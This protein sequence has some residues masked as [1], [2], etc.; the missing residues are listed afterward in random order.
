MG[1]QRTSDE[2]KE[3]IDAPYTHSIYA[4]REGLTQS[5]HPPK[6]FPLKET[7]SIYLL[8]NCIAFVHDW[9]CLG[10]CSLYFSFTSFEKSWFELFEKEKKER[11]T[12][13]LC[14]E[15]MEFRISLFSAPVSWIVS[16]MLFGRLRLTPDLTK[17]LSVLLTLRLHCVPE[18]LPG[19]SLTL[20]YEVWDLTES[21]VTWLPG[22]R[23]EKEGKNIHFR[24]NAIFQDIHSFK[25]IV[26]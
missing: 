8:W 3:P 26:Y 12:K 19:L 7:Q 11:G 20:R 2:V 5:P 23:A 10:F 4:F 24:E 16:G 9:L 1:A 21:Q 18:L 22:V 17:G 6:K 13:P 25:K 15:Y 14:L